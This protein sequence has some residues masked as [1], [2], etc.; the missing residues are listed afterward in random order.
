MGDGGS[1]CARTSTGP[2]CTAPAVALHCV[3]Q[4]PAEF[5]SA[6]TDR[7]QRVPGGTQGAAPIDLE[8][9]ADASE[10]IPILGSEGQDL[11]RARL[12][13]ARWALGQQRQRLPRF[14]LHLIHQRS[15]RVLTCAQEHTVEPQN[16]ITGLETGTGCRFPGLN[17]HHQ[18]AR[19]SFGGQ[20]HQ[21]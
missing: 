14:A 10:S 2:D 21:G 16:P 13:P 19:F 15:H 9:G 18:H 17:S 7:L 6:E 20:T 11:F 4:Q 3:A 1:P 5:R 12:L 8:L